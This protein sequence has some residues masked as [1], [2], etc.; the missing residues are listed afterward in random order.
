MRV[1]NAGQTQSI[2][3]RLQ[4]GAGRL[5]EA[6]RRVS[7]GLRVERMS[8]DPLGGSGIMQASAS[9]RGATQYERNVGQVTAKLDAEDGALGQ[10]TDLLS[11]AK[12]IGMQQ[13]GQPISAGGRAAAAAEVRQLLAQAV[14]IG[15]TRLGGEYLFG[16]TR[17]D[18]R[19]P[20]AAA[21]PPF[22][23]SDPPPAGSPAGTPNVPRLPDG[24][25]RV[26]IGAGLTMDGPHSG[27]EVFLAS[28]AGAT[29]GLLDGLHTLATAIDADDNDAIAAAM[30]RL[31]TSFEKLQGHVGQVG[32]RQNQADTVKA[33]LAALTNTLTAQKSDLSEVDME[34][35]ITEMVA[36]QTAYQA[37]ML[38]SSKVMGMS[39]TDYLR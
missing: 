29:D 18:G 36:R 19:P 8:D 17:N 33:S 35:A 27:A 30:T 24:D 39:L 32:A 22:V 26:E 6:Q 3:A 25:R 20:F 13:A 16:G 15:N 28:G 1:T 2:I 10:L 34:Q 12:E 31:D 14:D 37:A 38:A 4:Q 7:S 9:L 23:P 11:R 5:E 21:T